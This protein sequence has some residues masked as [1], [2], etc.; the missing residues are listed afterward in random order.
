MKSISISSNDEENEALLMHEIARQMKIC[1]DRRAQHLGLT[2]SQWRV[3]SV[4]RR[5]PGIKQT[6]LAE[7]IEVEPITLVRLLDRM[8]KAGWIE[9]RPDPKDRRANG[10]YLTPKV[11]AIVQEMRA[12]ALD[13]RREYLRDISGKEHAQLLFCLKKIKKNV[14]ALAANGD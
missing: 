8:Q 1:F 14:T 4:L 5:N 3:L 11:K 9:R 12:I 6:K 2:R 7:C 10:I 13:L